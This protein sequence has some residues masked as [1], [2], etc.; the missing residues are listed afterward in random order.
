MFLIE[1]SSDGSSDGTAPWARDGNNK[2]I[3]NA[4]RLTLMGVGD[5]SI[6]NALSQKLTSNLRKMVV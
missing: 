6:S 2:P 3:N 1:Y 5:Q 4:R